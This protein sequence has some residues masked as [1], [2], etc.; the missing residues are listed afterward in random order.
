MAFQ[1]TWQRTHPTGYEVSTKGDK[2]FS[3]L[4][5]L[6]PDGRTI[7]AWY[8]CDVKGHQ[9]GGTDWR[10]GKG[11]PPKYTWEGD[12]L[13]EMYL[14]LWRLWAL[15]HIHEMYELAGR[16]RIKHG[17]VLTDCHA[18]TPINQARALAQILTE[19]F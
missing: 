12:Q 11:R 15:H 18:S 4:V 16:V 7:E 2:R 9:P 8:Q 6:M 19:W 14:S 10:L 17:G 3:P 5:A 13:Y 1:F